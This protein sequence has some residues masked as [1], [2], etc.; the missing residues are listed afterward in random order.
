VTILLVPIA[1]GLL[2]I[3][4]AELGGS[5]GTYL[6]HLVGRKVTIG[7]L[8][9]RLGRTISIELRDAV[10]ANLPNGSKPAMITLG[11]LSAEIP[12]RGL[13]FGPLVVSKLDAARGY[14][15]LEHEDDGR[16][17]W[18][19]RTATRDIA[20]DEPNRLELPVILD[21]QFHDITVDFRSSS[22]RSLPTV[23]KEASLATANPDAA[24]SLKAKGSYR[25]L[26]L[27]LTADLASFA[28]LHRS[29]VPF[30]A[31]IDI[32]TE[33]NQLDFEGTFT[34]PLD[35][36]GAE[37]KL[38]LHAPSLVELANGAGIDG[39]PDVAVEITGRLTR[40]GDVTKI[41]DGHGTIAGQ[42]FGG[43]LELHE[44]APRQPDA[45]KL[46]AG[47]PRLDSNTIFKSSPGPSPGISLVMDPAPATLLDIHVT[48]G[49]LVYRTIAAD[50]FAIAAKIGVGTLS[51]D[52][53]ALSIAGGIARSK[54]SI[55]N[56]AAGKG[57]VSFDGSL[58]GVD[59]DKMGELLGWGPLPVDGAI[60]SRAIGSMIGADM[61]EAR[62]TNRIF[63]VVAMSSGTIDRDI[64]RKA[65]TDIRMLFGADNGV[66]KLQCLL[67]VLNLRDGKGTIGPVR[68]KSSAGTIAGGGTYD[69]VNDHI[70]LVIGAQSRSWFSLDVPVRIAGPV[71]D[72]SVVP[73]FGASRTLNDIRLPD[74]LPQSLKDIA[75]ASPCLGH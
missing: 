34:D 41:D 53:I 60:T 9:V 56:N 66:R 72:F 25:A 15:L 36:D 5:A 54:I 59:A 21:A 63:A 55:A 51:V 8:R 14:M 42:T 49:H 40:N 10:L 74:D 64:V 7:S 13:L 45:L 65:S 69:S 71:T 44:G 61:N 73:A 23:I 24:V 39:A 1:G 47:F 35:V 37:G 29:A 38:A 48:A 57:V 33:I 4:R 26:P 50:D 11:H 46:E 2:L 12:L 32:R 17:N 52:D 31:K 3:S 67:G 30:P 43:G 68:I 75:T 20:P 58:S 70:D 6:S 18:R 27:A 28:V 19:F 16:P 62:G 22:G